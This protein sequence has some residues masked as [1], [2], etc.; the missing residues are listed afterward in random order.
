MVS[1][2]QQMT[3]EFQKA[4]WEQAIGKAGKFVEAA[5]KALWVHVGK[6]LP[7]GRRFKVGDVIRGLANLPLGSFDDAVRLTIPRGCDFIF[8]IASNRGARHDPDEVDPNEI[9]AMAVVAVSSWT[10]SEMLRYSQKGSID[11]SRVQ[12]LLRALSERRY[13]HIEDVDGRVYFH[14]PRLSARAVGLLQLW[15]RYP[16]RMSKDELFESITRHRFS[17][18]NARM[19]VS[20]LVKLADDDGT[21]RLRLL[22]PG[23][24]EAEALVG[25][26]LRIARST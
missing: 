4:N 9:D 19:A 24:K 21:G 5:L 23:L 6:T 14:L 7:P 15:Y 3:E 11:R 20:R 12:A 16:A 13:P 25:S 26:D 22:Q 18:S 1:H 10:M 8:D 17:K 2:F